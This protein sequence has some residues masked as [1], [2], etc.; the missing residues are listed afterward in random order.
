LVLLSLL[1]SYVCF[2]R[3]WRH[4]K[5]GFVGET[6]IKTNERRNNQNNISAPGYFSSKFTGV[7]LHEEQRAVDSSTVL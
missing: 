4:I 3:L 5:R 7:Q 6:Q 2:I 1:L